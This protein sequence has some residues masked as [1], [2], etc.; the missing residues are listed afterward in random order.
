[1]P[2][3]KYVVGAPTYYVKLA[4]VSPILAAYFAKA[5]RN[6][7]AKK[8]V[9]RRYVANQDIHSLRAIGSRF[10]HY[11]IPQMLRPEGMERLRWHQEKG[12]ICVLVS[13]S[14][15]VYLIPW[16]QKEHFD[17]VICT[18]LILYP[19]KNKSR[20]IDKNCFGAEKSA[21]IQRWTAGRVIGKT[22]AYGDSQGDTHML[23]SVDYGYL[24]SQKQRK[25]VPYIPHSGI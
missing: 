19:D 3:L 9:L 22:F 2:F 20:I 10:S 17:D 7:I 18:Q 15:D 8:F 4:L 5:L 12:H 11:V 1:M 25:F 21:R 16:A 23:S 14:L 6:D 24:W 13:A